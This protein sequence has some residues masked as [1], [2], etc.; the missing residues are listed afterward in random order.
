MTL[1]AVVIP[2]YNEAESIGGILESLFEV[3][4][5]EG[6]DIHVLVVDDNSVDGTVEIVEE[7][8]RRMGFVSVLR[9]PGKLGLGSAY[10]DGFRWCLGNLGEFD[11]A[12][13]MDADGSHDPRE[14]GRLVKPIIGG[15]ADVVVGSRYIQGG[16]WR[17]GS[18]KR[19]IISRG[20][21]LLVRITVG[22]PVRDATSGYRAISRRVLERAY[23]ERTLY[24]SG[25][26]F[27]VETLLTYHRLGAKIVEAPI[28]F[29]ER[30][31]GKSKLALS[32]VFGFAWWCLRQLAR[33]VFRRTT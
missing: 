3:S 30:L 19:R 10:V 6:F 18:L 15:E 17:G 32:E 13:E 11:V 26:I 12:V 9:R 23:S 14:L 4:R 2:T 24:E 8:G 22:L 33:R 7:F 25:Y 28:N 1:V 20:A 31:G 29:Y 21:N 27:Q 16:G 5:D